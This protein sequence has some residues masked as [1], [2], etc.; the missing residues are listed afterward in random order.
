M[1]FLPPCKSSDQRILRYSGKPFNS[2]SSD[3]R[4]DSS[5]QNTSVSIGSP[6]A[7]IPTNQGRDSHFISQAAIK[8]HIDT[9]LSSWLK[10]GQYE[11][12][13]NATIRPQS[14]RVHSVL[15]VT[16]SIANSKHDALS[17]FTI[18]EG[19][20]K[21]QTEA[22]RLWVQQS[23]IVV[24]FC[25]WPIEPNEF[26]IHFVS[27]IPKSRKPSFDDAEYFSVK[28]I[29]IWDESFNIS[30][31]PSFGHV[32]SVYFCTHWSNPACFSQGTCGT[33]WMWFR[34]DMN[35]PIRQSLNEQIAKISWIF[36]PESD[37]SWRISLFSLC[38]WR[39]AHDWMS[40]SQEVYFN[41]RPQLFFTSWYSAGTRNKFGDFLWWREREST[42]A[43]RWLNWW[44][45]KKKQKPRS[46]KVPMIQRREL[47]LR[48]T[49]WQN[50]LKWSDIQKKQSWI[51]FQLSNCLA[52]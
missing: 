13:S 50:R 23:S 11:L 19:S 12:P 32:L 51:E 45:S 24:I 4:N 44:C 46:L 49:K 35:M 40:Q 20:S 48:G 10:Y 3:T 34:S 41:V 30:K 28:K 37:L 9:C 14:I 22:H 52:I 29:G 5:P 17:L 16:G 31:F 36:A 33:P 27:M 2:E 6:R 18:S 7:E 25:C 47:S 21:G 42:R 1:R 15:L 43:R 39:C 26:D 8:N 38:W